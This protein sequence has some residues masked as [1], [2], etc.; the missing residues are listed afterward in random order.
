MFIIQQDPD[1]EETY[2][3][4]MMRLALEC[5][6]ETTPQE[7][8]KWLA[9]VAASCTLAEAKALIHYSRDQVC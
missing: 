3:L 4:W 9:A 8:M 6:V 1:W 2:D 7:D 5:E